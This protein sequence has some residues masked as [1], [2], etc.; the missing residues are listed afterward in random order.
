MKDFNPMVYAI[1]EIIDV[2]N[3]QIRIIETRVDN[4]LKLVDAFLQSKQGDGFMPYS[5]LRHSLYPI[6]DELRAAS[7]F[8]SKGETK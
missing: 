6:Q 2:K 3:K 5:D 1:K 4:A 8:I 7:D